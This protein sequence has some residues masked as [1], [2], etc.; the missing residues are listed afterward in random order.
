MRPIGVF[1]SLAL[2][3]E[4]S[5]LIHD[6][7]LLP[8]QHGRILIMSAK[9]K[10]QNGLFSPAIHSAI[11]HANIVVG[12]LGDKQENVTYE[13]GLAIAH[14][15]PLI[16]ISRTPTMLPSMLNGHNALIVDGSRPLGQIR[17]QLSNRIHLA[18]NGDEDDVRRRVH[19]A[20]LTR[21]ERLPERL[22]TGLSTSVRTPYDDARD[23]YFAGDFAGA[24]AILEPIAKSPDSNPEEHFLLSDSYFFRAERDDDE[25]RREADYLRMGQVAKLALVRWNQH[26]LFLK[27]L[28]IALMK[29]GDHG[30]ARRMFEELLDHNNYADRGHYNLA[31]LHALQKEVFPC[32]QHLDRAIRARH[33][34][35]YMA[36]TDPDF[37]RIWSERVFQALLYPI[38]DKG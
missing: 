11:F 23:L 5:I 36:R 17:E 37:D 38:L 30:S 14:G 28:G 25:I 31:C 29:Q 21:Q 34:F 4:P 13:L 3:E 26:P 35:L 27:N 32:I 7:C 2:S 19:I 20:L 1:V 16:L 33:D 6:E 24:I 15:K 18:L 12:I 8:L 9:Q 10:P 22:T